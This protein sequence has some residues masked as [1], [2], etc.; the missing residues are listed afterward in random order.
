MMNSLKFKLRRSL[1]L[2][3]IQERVAHLTR[4]NQE[5]RDHNQVLDARLRDTLD[6]NHRILNQIEQ[7]VGKKKIQLL[8]EIIEQSKPGSIINCRMNYCDLLVP[9][10]LLQLCPHCL[11]PTEEKKL[12]Y[13]LETHCVDWLSSYIEPGDTILDIGA[14][15]GTISIPLAKIVGA[16]GHIYSFEPARKTH[17]FLQQII[18][19]NSI[20]NISVVKAAISEEPGTCEFVEYLN[21]DSFSWASETSTLNTPTRKSDFDCLTYEVQVT[22]IDDFVATHKI[23]PN[24]M[25]I[26][27]EGFELYALQGGKQTLEKYLPYLCIDI[28]PDVK[29][30]KTAL[31]GVEPFLQSLGYTV[32]MEQHTLCA[33]PPEK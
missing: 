29:T 19:I 24:A 17:N 32:T 3:E 33:T 28:H 12:N 2:N 6:Y 4:Q 27:I 20:N 21:S 22:T 11:H 10:E 5:L 14:S 18:E 15:F 23:T 8:Q 16:E 31:L 7:L 13:L 1:G 30:G 9:V 26:D 25:K